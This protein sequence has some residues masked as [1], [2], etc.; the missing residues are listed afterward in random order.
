MEYGL[1]R[2]APYFA[3]A[4]L[5]KEAR[6]ERSCFAFCAKYGFFNN[7]SLPAINAGIQ[8]LKDLIANA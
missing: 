2:T 8:F 3:F 6:G 4:L 1:A 7:G 5:S